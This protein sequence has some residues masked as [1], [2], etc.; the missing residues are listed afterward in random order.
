[1]AFKAT[2]SVA[3]TDIRVAYTHYRQRLSIRA[4]PDRLA[5][6]FYLYGSD[7]HDDICQA[8]EGQVLSYWHLANAVA[9]V[10]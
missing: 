6:L 4:Y 1:M 9:S 10:Q 8:G 3:V 7:A 5:H 2:I